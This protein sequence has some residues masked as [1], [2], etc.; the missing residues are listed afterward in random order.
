LLALRY[1]GN[2]DIRLEEIPEPQPGPGEVRVRVTFTGICATDIEEWQ[3]GPLWVQHGSPNPLTGRETPLTMGHEITG[4]VESV[5]ADVTDMR[6]GERVAINDVLTCGVCFWCKRWQQAVCPNMAVA[7]L[8]ADGGLAEFIVWPADMVVPLPDSVSDEEAALVEPTT[9]AVRAVRN[10]GVRAGDT[11]AIIGAGTV[12]LLTIQAFRASGARVIAVDIR[13][14]SLAAASSLGADH[15]VNATKDDVESKLLELTDGVGPDIV[16]ETA[17]AA[18][19]PVDAISWT[20][21]GGT[22][23]LVGIY[24]A[25]P[26]MNFNEIVGFERR[27]VGSVAIGPG[28]MAV[29]VGMIGSDRIRVTDLITAKIPLDRAIEDGFNRMLRPEKDVFRILISPSG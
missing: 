7:G 18:R 9:V 17:G 5:G 4:E 20:R 25:T 10:S 3:F 26:E 23:V 13:D 16:I 6:I 11:V 28:D 29:A 14:Q 27:V 8:S 21:R 2:K 1:Y 22:T 12:G 19:T 24:S 15:I